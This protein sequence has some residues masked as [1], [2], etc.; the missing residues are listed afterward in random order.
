MQSFMSLTVILYVSITDYPSEKKE[1]STENDYLFCRTREIPAQIYAPMNPY[2]NF[3]FKFHLLKF[4]RLM[5]NYRVQ[6]L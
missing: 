4:P 1:I 3:K 2:I 5:V 6:S